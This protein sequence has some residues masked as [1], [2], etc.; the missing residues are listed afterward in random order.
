MCLKTEFEGFSIDKN[1]QFNIK[2]LNKIIE[3]IR[4]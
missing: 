4:V 3:L 1:Q 2:I